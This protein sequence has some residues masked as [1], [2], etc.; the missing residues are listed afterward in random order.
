MQLRMLQL[1]HRVEGQMN[2]RFGERLRNSELGRIF[3]H[4][5]L[6]YFPKVL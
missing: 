4:P 5:L 3:G 2:R 1:V 6:I